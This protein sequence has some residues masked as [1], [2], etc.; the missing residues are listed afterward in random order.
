[1]RNFG[2]LIMLLVAV[3]LASA[4]A[5]DRKPLPSDVVRLKERIEI[6]S[7]LGGEVGSGDPYQEAAIIKTANS[8]NCDD[9]SISRDLKRLQNKYKNSP[10]ALKS[11]QKSLDVAQQNYGA[12]Y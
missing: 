5:K 12:E 2:L 8:L 3:G 4:Q 11:I 1:M 9:R 10:R 6:C 7:H